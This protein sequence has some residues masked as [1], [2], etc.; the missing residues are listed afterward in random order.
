[1]EGRELTKAGGRRNATA[2]VCLR[3]TDNRRGGGKYIE[4]K[5]FGLRDDRN[6]KGLAR[7]EVDRSRMV[8]K[9]A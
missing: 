6:G 1:V 7:Q 9:N 4:Q 5:E 8:S 2:A 3:E